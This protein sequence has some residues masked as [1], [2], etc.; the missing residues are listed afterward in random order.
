MTENYI[1]QSQYLFVVVPI[2]R[3]ITAETVKSSLAGAL[4]HSV[5]LGMDRVA[6]YFNVGVI[7]THSDVGFYF[8]RSVRSC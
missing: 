1:F 5:S 3:A 2:G 6:K 4:S 7:C 8:F